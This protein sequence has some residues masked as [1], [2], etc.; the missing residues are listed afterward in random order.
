M[1]L[2]DMGAQFV[3]NKVKDSVINPKLD[4]IGVIEEIVYKNKT[5]FLRIRLEDLEDHP[6]EAICSDVQVADDGSSVC[7]GK[8]KANKK[9]AQ[10]ALDNFVAG[11]TFTIPAGGARL[12][13]VAAKKLLGL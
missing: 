7:V 12:A 10:T 6:I 9:F 4:G 11:Q 3:L 13:L 1:G 5:L 8:F 2:F